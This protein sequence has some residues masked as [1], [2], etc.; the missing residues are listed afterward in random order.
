[1]RSSGA[2]WYWVV[3]LDSAFRRD[4]SGQVRS[5]VTTL[6][7]AVMQGWENRA[8]ERNKVPRVTEMLEAYPK[9]LGGFDRAKLAECIEACFDCAQVC[10]ACADAC[11]AEDM[12]SELVHCIRTDLDCA[13]I[14]ATTGDDAVPP[15]R[16]RRQRH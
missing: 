1:M 15:H 6:A 14:C 13:D 3:D 2:H 11:L 10:T 5:V 4:S 16:L 7:L 8:T 9:Y 12:V